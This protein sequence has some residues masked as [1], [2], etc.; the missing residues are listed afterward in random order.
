MAADAFDDLVMDV[1]DITGIGPMEVH[2]VLETAIMFDEPG[3]DIAEICRKHVDG[4][5]S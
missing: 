2:R 4:C 3:E 1:S 5:G